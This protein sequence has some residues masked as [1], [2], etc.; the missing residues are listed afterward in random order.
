MLS[1]GEAAKHTGFSKPTL[2]RAIKNGKLSANRLDDGSYQIDPAELQRWQENNGHKNH[3][4]TPHATDEVT[5]ETPDET[6]VLQAEVRFLREQV[7][8]LKGERERER[9]LL[10]DQLS[11]VRQDRDHWREQAERATRLLAAPPPVPP[12]E[13]VA[14]PPTATAERPS[15]L[16]RRFGRSKRES[17]CV[18][19]LGTS[20][21]MQV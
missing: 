13:A 15:L 6:G 14:A 16:S 19:L 10:S 18:Q 8:A 4:V 5:P 20:S 12:A 2:S 1:L 9:A 7:E 11:D 17:R 21:A 3:P